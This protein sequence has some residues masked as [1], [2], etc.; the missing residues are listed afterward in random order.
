MTRRNIVA[1]GNGGGLND[2]HY[3]YVLQSLLDPSRFYTGETADL[4]KRLGEHNAGKSVHTNKFKPWKVYCYFAFDT[5]EKAQKFEQ[6]LKTA[7]G[8]RFLIRHC[9]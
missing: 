3:V 4:R 9:G 2:M 6:Y 8:R 7:S 5:Q 1:A